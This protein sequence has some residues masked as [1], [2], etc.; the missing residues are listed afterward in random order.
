MRLSS[1]T[2]A[3]GDRA[4]PCRAAI[5]TIIAIASATGEVIISQHHLVTYP[6]NQRR[7][8]TTHWGKH[9]K[10]RR[11]TVDES[12][13]GLVIQTTDAAEPVPSGAM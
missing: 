13:N 1:T 9:P 8:Q 4:Y 6:P 11:S 10:P 12:N 2:K 3:T 5:L 7:R